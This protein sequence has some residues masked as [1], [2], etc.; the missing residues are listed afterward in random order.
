M[1]MILLPSSACLV[2]IS[3]AIIYYIFDVQVRILHI[4]I[5]E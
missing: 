1:K 5:R 3:I 2:Y 4:F